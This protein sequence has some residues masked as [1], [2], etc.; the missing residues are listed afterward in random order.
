MRKNGGDD[1]AFPINKKKTK[2]MSNDIDNGRSTNTM[3]QATQRKILDA[4]QAMLTENGTDGFSVE[5]IAGRAGVT[6]GTLLYH[7]KNKNNILRLLT[8]EYA[9]HLEERLQLGMDT[10]KEKWPDHDAIV[11]G[12]VE[13]YRQFLLEPTNYTN[14]G[15]LILQ[16]AS[17]QPDLLE[18]INRWYASL[19]DRLRATRMH[20]EAL[21]VV[22][23]LEGLF[24]LNHFHLSVLNAKETQKLLDKLLALSKCR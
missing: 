21:F 23:T 17:T 19:F 7:F 11:A 6:K 15:T 22:L 13:W 24:F 18:P 1:L 3:G 10:A 16:I 2:A 5:R 12:F 4:A 9:G 14:Y 20:E 8:E